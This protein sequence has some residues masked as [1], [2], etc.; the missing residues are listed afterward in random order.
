LI[1]QYLSLQEKL[2]ALHP[3]RVVDSISEPLKVKPR[4]ALNTAVSLVL[5]LMVGIFAALVR[6]WWAYSRQATNAQP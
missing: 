3:A 6:N 4:L 5:G 2:A 1:A